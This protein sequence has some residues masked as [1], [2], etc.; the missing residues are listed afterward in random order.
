[1]NRKIIH[2]DMDAFFAAV[3][4]LDNKKLRGKPVIVGGTSNRG[5]V[6]TCSYEAREFGVHSAMPIFMAKKLCPKGIFL[7][8]RHSRYQEISENIFKLLCEITYDIEKVSIDEAYLD[9]TALYNSPENIAQYIKNRV[10]EEIGLTVSVG[11][12]YNKFLAKLSSD[13]D[14][15]DGLFQIKEEDVPNILKPLPIEKIHGLGSV[16]AKRLNK[17]GIFTVEDLLKYSKQ[18]LQDILGSMGEEVYLRIRG[19][20]DRQVKSS[21]VRKSI[22]TEVTLSKD[23][24]DIVLISK[25]LDDYLRKICDEIVQKKILAKTITLKIKF[26]DF[27][28]I[29]RSKSLENAS[30]N[31]NLFKVLLNDIINKVPIDRKIRLLGVT[32]SNLVENDKM[33]LELFDIIGENNE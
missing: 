3:E 28:Q 29:T 7:K 13:W 22:G 32:L 21:G 12:S 2:V 10:K 9:V 1:M 14:K 16:S 33:Q 23:I 25:Y 27:Q 26:D 20:D 6:S 30:N 4:Q 5:V 24:D 11:I 19:I 31:Y 18:V 17:I 15:P 8:G